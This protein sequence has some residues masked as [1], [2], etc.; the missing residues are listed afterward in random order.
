MEY[1][2][3]ASTLKEAIEE[4]ISRVASRSVSAD[5]VSLYDSVKITSR[6]R[7]T[8]ERMIEDMESVLMSR[9]RD[10]TSFV[11]E[12][13]ITLNLPDLPCGYEDKIEAE[14]NRAVTM[15]VVAYWLE[16][17]NVQESANYLA[18]SNRSLD[19][20]ELLMITR[21]TM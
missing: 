21:D 7:G 10:F 12:H 17:R 8:I 13:S 1:T 18:R 11:A 5:G 20:A 2:I 6:D 16:E 9:F 15:G 3:N 19:K 4:E 14:L